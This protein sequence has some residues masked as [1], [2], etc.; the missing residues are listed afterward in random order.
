MVINLLLA[1]L[2]LACPTQWDCMF[3]EAAAFNQPIGQWDVSSVTHGTSQWDSDTMFCGAISFYRPIGQWI[4]TQ[5]D[6]VDALCYDAYL[7]VHYSVG[8]RRST[9]P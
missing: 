6:S 7:T 2:E 1:L 4:T 8:S 3:H 5:L 9:S